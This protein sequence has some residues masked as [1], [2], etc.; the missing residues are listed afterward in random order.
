MFTTIQYRICC[1]SACSQQYQILV[2]TDLVH[3]ADT[4]LLTHAELHRLRTFKNSAL[5]KMLEY[6]RK[7][8][9]NNMTVIKSEKMGWTDFVSRISVMRNT[10]IILL[11]TPE[12]GS[13]LKGYRNR[14]EDIKM[15]FVIAGWI[16][17]FWHSD[18]RKAGINATV[19]FHIPQSAIS[20]L[21]E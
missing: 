18:H 13:P 3:R 14:W 16:C 8:V 17:I 19:N 12:C 11:R 1:R 9:P 15:W 4:C 21:A 20:C 5:R 6:M 2:L 7:K 10:C